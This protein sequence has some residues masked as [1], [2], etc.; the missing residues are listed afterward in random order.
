MIAEKIAKFQIYFYILLAIIILLVL[1]KFSN[2]LMV[3]FGF[4]KAQ[5]II[6][7]EKEFD[8]QL[9]E[10]NNSLYDKGVR[11]SYPISTYIEMA[12]GLESSMFDLGADSDFIYKTFESLK[13]QI[14]Y[15]LLVKEFGLRPYFT[16]GIKQG[17]WTLTQ[18][19][20]SEYQVDTKKIKNILSK[21]GIVSAV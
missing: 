5:D 1:Y 18:W 2:N 16:F 17:D 12:N 19:L 3:L 9:Q 4:K 7:E 21:K 8:S 20:N 14:D 11:A 13:N 15:N 10:E 6:K